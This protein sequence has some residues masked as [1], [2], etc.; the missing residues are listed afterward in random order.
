MKIANALVSKNGSVTKPEGVKVNQRFSG[1][2]Q[3]DIGGSYTAVQ[4]V[5]R[6][7]IIIV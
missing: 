3:A 2:Q 6:K 7:P 5:L 1:F 4:V